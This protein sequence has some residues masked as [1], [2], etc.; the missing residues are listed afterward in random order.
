MQRFESR[1]AGYTASDYVFTKPAAGSYHPQA[2]SKTLAL[3]SALAGLPRLTAH[4][5][6]TP[7]PRSC[8]QAAYRRRSRPNDSGTDATLFLN[9][10]GHVTPTVQRDAADKVGKALFGEP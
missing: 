3:L 8:L 9:F 4:G 6:A 7:V 1:R 10:Y 5:C 2:V